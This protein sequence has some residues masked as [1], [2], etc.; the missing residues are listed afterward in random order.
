VRIIWQNDRFE[1]QLS[2]GEHWQ[3]DMEAC[4]A[5]GFKTDGPPTWTWAAVKAAPLVKLRENRPPSGL[6]V[7]PEA[8]SK[9]QAMSQEEEKN[10]ALLLTLK[11]AKKKIRKVQEIEQRESA[12][13]D[14]WKKGEFGREDL[15]PEVIARSKSLLDWKRPKPPKE[16]CINCDG[17]VYFYEQQDPPMCLW[18]EMHPG[19]PVEI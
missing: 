15:P 11:D 14:Y 6:S 3:P 18:C 5:A 13:P 16:T 2:P 12:L 7:T 4:K 8:F 17:P 19:W 1:A 10:A 9:F